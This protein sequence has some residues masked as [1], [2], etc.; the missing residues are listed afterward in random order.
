MIDRERFEHLAALSGSGEASAAEQSE[1]AVLLAEHPELATEIADQNSTD[2]MIRS[3]VAI[4]EDTPLPP[5]VLQFLE[6]SRRDALSARTAEVASPEA[7]DKIAPFKSERPPRHAW[8]TG[9]ALAA[10]LALLAG[11]AAVWLR[12][13]A[14]SSKD[15]VILA[16]RGETGF[17]QPTIAWDAKAGQRYDVWILGAEGSHLDAPA[18]YIAKGVQ[19]PLSLAAL[20]PGPALQGQPNPRATLLPGTDYRLL[21]CLADAG[22][23]A[24][25]A[26][27]FR[28]APDASDALPP[29]SLA[30]AQK[31]ATQGRPADALML[32]LQLPP[33]EREQ[34]D[35][36][37]LEHE[38]RNRLPKNTT[39]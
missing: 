3:T 5:A 39:P 38:L 36:Q 17:T 21:V 37:N 30:A 1:L 18:L 6:K 14:A 19:P 25:I 4:V 27:P 9:L 35:V 20:Q 15:I 13:P 33:A 12:P 24:G 7:G 8:S 31:L 10:C 22:R 23:I 29:P 11:L 26:V 2:Q 28:T 16:P 32:L 34:A